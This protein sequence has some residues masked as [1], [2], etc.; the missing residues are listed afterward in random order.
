MVLVNDRLVRLP[1]QWL[2]TTNCRSRLRPAVN[3]LS[4]LAHGQYPEGTH[5]YWPVWSVAQSVDLLAGRRADSLVV[6]AVR[7]FF[8]S[9]RISCIQVRA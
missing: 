2:Q 1:G 7:P 5:V 8:Y 3:D 6:R 9:R 4:A